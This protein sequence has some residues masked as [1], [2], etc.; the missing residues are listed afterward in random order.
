MP[1]LDPGRILIAGGGIGGLALALAL[2]RTGRE[3]LVLE[4]RPEFGTAG[5]GIQIGPNGVRILSALGVAGALRPLAGRPEAIRVHRGDTGRRLA[6]LPLGTWIAERHGAPYWVLHRADLHEALRAEAERSP[7]VS[8]KTG[9]SV[10]LARR[11]AEGVRV[12]SD[13]KESATGAAL[14]GADGLWSNVRRMVAPEGVPVFAGASASRCVLPAEAAGPLPMRAVGLWL[15]PTAH[16]VH[17]P[18]RGGRE[19]AIVVIAKEDWESRAW[20][21]AAERAQ[22]LDKVSA[23]HAD[24]RA[25]LAAAPQWRRWSLHRLPTL[26]AWSR[27]R[28]VLIGDAAHPMF[29]YLAQ[30]GVMAL[31][32]AWCLARA[33]AASR[34][35]EE[36]AIDA[37]VAERRGR[38]ARVQAASARN[39]RIYHLGP[40]LSLA[41]DAVLATV[42]GARLMARFDWLYGWGQE[43]G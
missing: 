13:G 6:D 43:I 22:V 16:V 35:V 42:P 17:Y 9:F 24:L 36:R 3:S 21:A 40:P 19:L 38:A 23:F 2:A 10:R 32:D 25:V 8:F 39:G 18:I 1:L 7:L 28:V 30:G 31:E 29:P 27:D 14:V 11:D 41:R 20:D 33:F 34:G 15:S 26:S 12:Q 5:A 4:A 37:Y